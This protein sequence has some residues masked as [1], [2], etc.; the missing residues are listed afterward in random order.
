MQKKN[1][2]NI[3]YIDVQLPFSG[4]YNSPHGRAIYDAVG[5]N[6]YYQPLD[7][8]DDLKQGYPNDDEAILQDIKEK[9][10][11]HVD[12]VISDIK[13]DAKVAYGEVYSERFC[14]DAGLD[15]DVEKTEVESPQYYNYTT[16]RIFTPINIDGLTKL[17][18]AAPDEVLAAAVR[19]TYT[20]YDGFISGFDNDYYNGDDWNRP[21][22]D[23]QAVQLGTLL[24]AALKHYNNWSIE[25]EWYLVDEPHLVVEEFITKEEYDHANDIATEYEEALKR[26]DGITPLQ[27]SDAPEGMQPEL[28]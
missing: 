28:S 14:D 17:L 7:W 22:K 18:A 10:Y 26:L 3:E 16:D 12:T 9:A 6:L 21:L 15:C 27:G 25:G 19:D 11:E 4:F 5:S 13:D 23:M 20:S 8:Y 2:K 24:K 1:K